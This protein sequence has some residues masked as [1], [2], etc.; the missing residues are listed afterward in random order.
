MADTVGQNDERVS[1]QPKVAVRALQGEIC[2][3]P[4]QVGY[5]PLALGQHV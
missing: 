3:G 1:A 2:N 4:V 5:V